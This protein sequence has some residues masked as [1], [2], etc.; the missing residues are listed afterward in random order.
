MNHGNPIYLSPHYDDAAF[1]CGGTIHRQHRTG[2]R[3]TVVTIFAA[4]P[5]PHAPLSSLARDLHGHMG[6]GDDPVPIRRQEDRLAMARLGAESHRLPFQDCIYRGAPDHGNW[7][8]P[9]MD[10]VFGPVDPRDE[11]LVRAI[12]DAAEALCHGIP[13]PVFYTPLGIGNHVDHQLTHR[14]GCL[15]FERGEAV[16]FYEDYPYTDPAHS[17]NADKKSP[18]PLQAAI[19]AM[20]IRGA[21][22]VLSP[23][24]ESDLQARVDSMCIY[25]S[26]LGD[27]PDA[28]HVIGR[29]LRENVLRSDPP[30]MTERFWRIE[31]KNSAD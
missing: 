18:Y 12:A 19:S 27:L 14:A 6:C 26:Q 21:T 28:A 9:G 1:S 10:D 7:F 16:T 13:T 30:R 17:S 2:R 31:K 24:N 15:L 11:P 20:A 29:H 5:P 8:Y 25:R 22:E 3:V 23:L 4:P